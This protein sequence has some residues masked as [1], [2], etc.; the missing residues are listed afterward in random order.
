MRTHSGVASRMFQALAK[1]GINIVMIGTSEI[2]ISCLIE[3]KYAELA[4]QT[5]HE[6]FDLASR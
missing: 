4:L 6:V 5:L 1:E 3:E 2:R